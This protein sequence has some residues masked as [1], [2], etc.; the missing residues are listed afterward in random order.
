LRLETIT[1]PKLL[2][3]HLR[4]SPVK[5]ILTGSDFHEQAS[6]YQAFCSQN[7][8]PAIDVQPISVMNSCPEGLWSLP[9]LNILK[10]LTIPESRA[11]I[12]FFSSGSTGTPKGVIHSRALLC[13]R[14]RLSPDDGWLFHRP[15][16]WMGGSMP[17]PLIVLGGARAEIIDP[18]APAQEYW[19]R[20]RTDKITTIM[21]NVVLWDKLARHYK[22]HLRNH[23]D[24]DEYLAGIRNL[25]NPI[26]SA[27]VPTPSLL[28]FYREEIQKPLNIAY[29][30]TEAGKAVIGMSAE[31]DKKLIEHVCDNSITPVLFPF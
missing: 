28:K 6:E 9:H 25:R 1:T 20:L 15:A 12:V 26:I 21:S 11:G 30:S 14:P 3:H 5:Y 7:F 8:L 29:G 16:S 24:R 31:E 13:N 22:T 23:P 10:G 4:R 18:A 2:L 19:E 27:S 17:V